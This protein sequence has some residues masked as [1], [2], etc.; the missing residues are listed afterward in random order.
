MHKSR[1]AR[2][3]VC[4]HEWGPLLISGSRTNGKVYS[5]H[6]QKCGHC[7]LIEPV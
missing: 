5:K 4:N 1:R 3:S 7:G 6:Y 2:W